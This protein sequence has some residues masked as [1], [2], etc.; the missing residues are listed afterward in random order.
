MTVF[1]Y[2]EADADNPLRNLA[3]A[4]VG[5]LP[6]GA[7]ELDPAGKV[8][9][10]I[11]TEPGDAGGGGVVTGHD[12]FAQVAPWAGNSVIGTEFRRGVTEN[13]LNA[14]FDCA[15]SGLSYKVRVHLKVSPILGTFWVFL[16]RLTRTP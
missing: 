6:F 10:Y 3:A 5:R 9:S 11:D 13:A 15:V 1:S 8:V 14:V 4:Q 16:K 2:E 7:V 12:F